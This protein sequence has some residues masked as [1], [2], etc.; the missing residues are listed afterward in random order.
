M[1]QYEYDFSGH[2]PNFVWRFLAITFFFIFAIP[3]L[4]IALI[5]QSSIY[6]NYI[7]TISPKEQAVLCNETKIILERSTKNIKVFEVSRDEIELS[8]EVRSF[9]TNMSGYLGKYD[10]AYTSFPL[11]ENSTVTIEKLE[12]FSS[13][14]YAFKGKENMEKYFDGYKSSYKYEVRIRWENDTY[15]FQANESD[16]YYIA[17][18][19]SSSSSSYYPS[20]TH[21]SVEY[22]VELITYETRNL[23]RKCESEFECKLNKHKKRDFCIIMDYNV[24]ESS[25]N[26]KIKI[27]ILDEGK[28]NI[29]IGFYCGFAGTLAIIIGL[30]TYG[31]IKTQR[32]K[33]KDQ[34][35][36]QHFP[37]DYKPQPY[38]TKYDSSSLREF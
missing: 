19:S 34:M 33:R 10:Y 37:A 31:V 24:S 3:F 13:Y 26:G 16:D 36:Y 29:V 1:D 18:E 14:L 27:S 22:F 23:T 15:T 21:Y 2:K 28:Q 25:K 4:F 11:T 20:S 30:V 7:Y 17:L 6:I 8:D 35:D 12:N 38:E 32:L 5:I 9:S